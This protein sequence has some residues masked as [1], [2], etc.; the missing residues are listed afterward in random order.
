MDAKEDEV[1]A[2]EDEVEDPPIKLRINRTIMTGKMRM[3]ILRTRRFSAA[4][5]HVAALVPSSGKDSTAIG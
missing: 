3:S 2:K 4:A 5:S 1:D